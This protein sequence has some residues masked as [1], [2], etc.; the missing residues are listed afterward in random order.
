MPLLGERVYVLNPFS[1]QFLVGW[2]ATLDSV[3]DI[4]MLAHLPTFLDGLFHMLS[5]PNKEIR[6]QTY[7][8][9][10]EFLREI[11]DAEAVSYAPILQVSCARAVALQGGG[12]PD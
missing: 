7:A 8:V 5:D 3:P 12:P 6:S 1:R 2:V 4:E 10:E 9:L 11:R